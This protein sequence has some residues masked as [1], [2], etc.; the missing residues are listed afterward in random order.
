MEIDHYSSPDDYFSLFFEICFSE[1]FKKK[2]RYNK[3]YALVLKKLFDINVIM[4]ITF[5]KKGAWLYEPKKTLT[6]LYNFIKRNKQY[7]VRD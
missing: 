1:N 3:S 2:H 5:N 6:Y 7:I 4:C